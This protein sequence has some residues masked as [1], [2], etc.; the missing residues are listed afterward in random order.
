M[1]DA[2]HL[3]ILKRGGQAWNQW[4]SEH[5]GVPVDLTGADLIGARLG[6]A[7]LSHAH[8][9]RAILS[10]AD[11]RGADLSGADLGG[12]RLN[13]ADL[14]GA[15][16]GGA[17]LN[18]AN[19]RGVRLGG[20]DLEGTDLGGAD[21][22][23][24]DLTDAVLTGAVLR[25]VDLRGACLRGARLSGADFAESLLASTT[26]ADTD[27]VEAKG[28]ETIRHLSPSTVGTDTLYRSAGKIPEAFL[29]G[30]GLSDW[31]IESAKLYQP[32]LSNEEI[33]DILYRVHDL[34]AQQ[35]LQ[36]SPLFIS[37]SHTDAPFID[38]LEILLKG[39]GVRF[40]RDVHHST[41]GRLERQIDRA[42]R[43]NPTVLLVL[44]E[45]SVRSDW[46]EDEARLARKLELETGRDVLCPV[47]LDDSWK[48][49]RWPERLRE[50]IEEYNILDFSNW[51]DFD[52]MRRM[53]TRLIEGLGLFYK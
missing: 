38:R 18:H 30:C 27:L 25:H 21:L 34:R 36:I 50:Q 41:A 8:L 42:I 3:E 48:T 32:E 6:L 52:Y 47:A 39:K 9:N 26:F 13:R 35:A 24:S 37:Y 44:S 45:R 17:V 23:G 2:K 1:A 51:E 31:Q 19:L 29:R 15:R 43:H 4:R 20:A 7:D 46:V 53:F 16:L 49:S 5:G 10:G 28:L 33:T 11:L 14:K 12:A 40:W 22:N